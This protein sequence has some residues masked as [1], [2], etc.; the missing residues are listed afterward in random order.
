MDSAPENEH[1]VASSETHEPLPAPGAG[2]NTV[3]PP[4]PVS[5]PAFGTALLVEGA[6]HVQ[7]PGPGQQRPPQTPLVHWL[8]E[9]QT[10]PVPFFATHIVE[11]LVQ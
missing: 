11:S 4:N 10:W 5:N 2:S 6:G 9:V 8:L 1:E 3:H 7:A